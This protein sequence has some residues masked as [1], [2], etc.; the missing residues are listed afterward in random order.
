VAEVSAGGRFGATAS[1]CGLAGYRRVADVT[2]L[3]VELP[4]NYTE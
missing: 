1:D 4:G 2:A 3:F